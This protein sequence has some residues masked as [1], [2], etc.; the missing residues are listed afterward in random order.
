[1]THHPSSDRSIWKSLNNHGI[2]TE[3]TREPLPSGQAINLRF[4]SAI[5]L[6]YSQG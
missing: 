5:A 4:A 2:H 1:M 6:L 3:S